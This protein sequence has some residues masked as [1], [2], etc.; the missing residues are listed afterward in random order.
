MAYCELVAYNHVSEPDS[1]LRLF[2]RVL[3][4]VKLRINGA[5]LQ[6]QATFKFQLVDA[7]GDAFVLQ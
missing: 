3:M 6:V 4:L 5:K 1:F 2:I 7:S